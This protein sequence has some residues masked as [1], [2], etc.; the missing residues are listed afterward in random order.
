[1]DIIVSDDGLQHHRL[2][3]D[4]ELVVFDGRGAGNG[5]TL[6]AGPLREPL[7]SRLPPHWAVLYNAEQPSTH[8]PGPVA[9]RALAGALPLDDWR[10]GRFDALLPLAALA[11]RPLLAA[12]G[13]GDPERFFRM[14]EQAGLQIARL[15]LPDHARF[16]PL[17]WPASTPDVVVTEKDAVKLLPD[18]T[19]AT[20]VWVVALD[21]SLPSGCTDALR[22]RLPAPPS[23]TS[24]TPR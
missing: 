4:A 11:Q 1:V 12:A 14:L 24:P 23:S 22:Q 21:F 15:P 17:P 6:P 8:L 3:R 13:I 19:G 20:R 10:A 2:A 5:L 16:A 18:S 9:T 7:P